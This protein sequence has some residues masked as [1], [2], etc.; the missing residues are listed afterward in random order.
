MIASLAATLA[1]ASAPAAASSAPALTPLQTTAL[2]CGVVFA[3]G[4]RLQAA[5]EPGTAD[6]PDLGTRGKEYFVRASAKLIDETGIAAATLSQIAS[7]EAQ[8]LADNSAVKAAM[9]GC[10]PLLNAAGL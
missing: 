3:I 9:P 8:A 5:G 6:W 2:R 7:R 4:A 10:L 1:L